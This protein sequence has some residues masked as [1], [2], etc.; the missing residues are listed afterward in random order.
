MSNPLESPYGSHG[1]V[2]SFEDLLKC[3]KQSRTDVINND[4]CAVYLRV[5]GTLRYR[6]EICYVVIVCTKYDD[7]LECFPSL[8]SWSDVFDHKGLVL[9]SGEV[10]MDF[11]ELQENVDLKVKHV[12]KCAP[13]RQYSCY[14]T[15]AFAFY[16]PEDSSDFMLKCSKEMVTEIDA[17]HR[18]SRQ[19]VRKRCLT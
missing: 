15:S 17:S 6:F 18:C 8:H 7:E 11:L 16:Y 12:I 1:F 9:P 2:V 19:C 3:Y 13:R 4:D 14:E 5:G 10:D